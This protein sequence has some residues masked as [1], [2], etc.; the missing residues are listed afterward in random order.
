MLRINKIAVLGSGLMGSGI[1]CHLAGCGFEIILLDLPADGTFRNERVLKG[2]ESCI[3]SKPSPLYAKKLRSRIQIG[4][5]EDDLHRIKECDWIFEAVIENLSIKQG[6]FAKIEVFRK[7]DCIV[8]SNTS[9]IPIHFL[10][11]G[12][13]EE[14][15]QH[16]VGTHFFNPPRYLKLL[17]II[18]T[19]E[20]KKDILDFVVSF[21]K[22]HLGKQA[23]VCKDT[24]AFIANRI[25]VVAM[26]K[27]F[28]L[29]VQLKL[30]ISDVD[31]LTGPAIGRPKSGTFRLTDLVGLD[32][33]VWVIE[34]LKKNCPD[35]LLLQQ[36]QLPDCI[37]YLVKNKWFGNKS[38]KGFYLKSDEKDAK[39]RT[40]FLSL[41]LE[42]LEYRFDPK[43]N[44]ES[45]QVAKQIEDLGKRIKALL[46]TKDAG[47][48]LIRKS[49]GFLF[50]YCSHR[51]PEISDSIYAIDEAMKAGFGWELGPFE[52]W[53][54]IGF[55][56]G[57]QLVSEMNLKPAAWIEDMQAQGK[58]S[59]YQTEHPHLMVLDP[60][61]LSY[62]KLPGKEGDIQLNLIHSDNCVYKNDEL[63]LKDIGDGVLCAE[64]K[65]KYNVIG[66]GILR[67]LQE[68]IL[69]AE[70]QKWNGLV[71]GNNATN[72]TV[73]ANLML[74]GMFA[75]QQ[76]YEQLEMAVRL[77]QET[78]MRC[79]YSSIPV[80]TA[81]QG[82][83][84]GGGVELLMHCDAA[85]C[86]AESYI[87]LVEMG[88]G[89][90]PGGAGTKEFAVRL[91]DEFK[92][93]DV[94]IPQLIH[95]FKTLA[96]AAV[97][98]SAFEAYDLGYLNTSRDSICLYNGLQIQQAKDRVLLLSDNYVKPIP[99]NDIQ[100]LG[101]TGL[102]AL[103]TAAHTLKLGGYATDHDIKIA[104]KIAY[105]ICGGDLSYSQFVS[106]QYLL[107]LEREAFLSL[108]TE[109]KT[110][111]RIQ[112]ML[113]N[114]KALRN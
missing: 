72:F 21:S 92:E 63:Q 67:G 14:F 5:F 95:R 94:Q 91:S 17:E 55:D 102:A 114:N 73:G 103:L 71:I 9:G 22:S 36:I 113:E 74:I 47:G 75:F 16:F 2:L 54:A 76:E 111:E 33:A 79:R 35:D 45:L 43:S 23:V 85:V 4:N 90:L 50:A 104:Q 41:D 80:V 89:L 86:A 13:S 25:G 24:P 97:A 56:N 57:L 28:E 69:I 19:A 112:Y 18:P 3:A 101:R 108:C 96:T 64:F 46:K 106:E 27:L 6:L 98:T 59:F 39:G 10:T 48:E 65:S 87:G 82:Y 105:V 83:V 38:G 30:N 32:T 99:R 42:T 52:I 7:K 49:F 53:D 110:L 78:S 60:A 40:R 93:G 77:F 20:T 8:S 12:R 81:T 70:T 66:E 37:S 26:S 29:S 62:S 34:G 1:A 58:H 109:A 88:V 15:K 44:L 61:S 68:S 11:E 51:I 31:K 100:V 84:F 107:D